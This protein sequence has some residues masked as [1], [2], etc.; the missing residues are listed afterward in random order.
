MWK[1]TQI[2]LI[3][4]AIFDLSYFGYYGWAAVI[5]A[6]S[7]TVS[8]Y[9]VKQTNPNAAIPTAFYMVAATVLGAFYAFKL[10]NVLFIGLFC[11]P[12]LLC[13]AWQI[14]MLPKFLNKKQT[15]SAN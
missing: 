14:L 3:G 10:G 12:L 13:N 1:A 11:V 5:L 9:K 8:I 7:I 6:I 2:V 15:S 4:L